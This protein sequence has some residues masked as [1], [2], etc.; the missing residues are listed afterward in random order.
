MA[1]T[2]KKSLAYK[3]E[4]GIVNYL[5]KTGAYKGCG[6]VERSSADEAPESLPCIIVNCEQTSRSDDMPIA[7]YSKDANIICTLYVDSDETTQAKMEELALDLEYRMENLEALQAEFNKPSSGRDK[8]KTRG[9]HIH[10]ISE[11]QTDQETEGN[12]WKYGIAL[13]LTLQETANQ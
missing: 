3:I 8:R 9:I 2:R 6:I 11:F 4:S 13:T 1:I 10:Y 7:C 5:R 12:D